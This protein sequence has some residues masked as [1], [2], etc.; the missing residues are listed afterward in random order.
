MKKKC[1]PSFSFSDMVDFVLKILKK[2]ELR[3]FGEPDS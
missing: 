3:D 1:I 2:L